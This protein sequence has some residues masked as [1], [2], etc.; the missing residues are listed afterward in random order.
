[1]PYTITKEAYSFAELSDRAKERA[2]DW[3]RQGNLDYDRDQF[4]I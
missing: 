4:G 2:R 3:Y 1:M